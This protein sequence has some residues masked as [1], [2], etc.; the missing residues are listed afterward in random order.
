MFSSNLPEPTPVALDPSLQQLVPPPSTQPTASVPAWDMD[1][2]PAI[3]L[4]EPPSQSQRNVRQARRNDRA[5]D[6]IRAERSQSRKGRTRGAPNYRPR[7]VMMLLDLVDQELPVG[8]KGW[9][10]VG[11]RF[12]EWAGITEHPARTD[13]SL[14]IKYKQVGYHMLLP[15]YPLLISAGASW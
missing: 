10:I 14:E 7:E 11:A 5:Y 2:D 15:V 12:R 8:A 1:P 6:P 13:R 9:N 3:A 4:Q